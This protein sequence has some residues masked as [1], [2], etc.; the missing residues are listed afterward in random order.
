MKK[1]LIFLFLLVLFSG[2]NQVA[3]THT[4][5]FDENVEIEYSTHVDTTQYVRRVDAFIIDN[6][7]R[8]DYEINVSNFTVSC[9]KLDNKSLG[10]IELLYK[11]NNEIYPLKATIV[12]SIKPLIKVKD[13]TL[14]FKWGKFSKK[15]LL[16]NIIVKDNY[17][18]KEDIKIS[19]VG[20]DSVNKEKSGEYKVTVLA[21]DTSGNQSSKDIKI[22]IEE[23]EE[24]KKEEE[25]VSVNESNNQ[26][27]LENSG[28][29]NLQIQNQ[30]NTQ[31]ESTNI[32][33]QQSSVQNKDYL[34]SDGYDMNSAPSACQADLL[35]SGRSGYCIPIKNEEG[36][37]LGM[38]LTLN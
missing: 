23:K 2:C 3:N 27:T 37:Y 36:I 25:D 14:S 20:L 16:K 13:S 28:Q 9:P 29:N 26:K 34:F 5:I 7:M 22:I 10:Q 12:D 8:G 4:I 35:N 17:D 30:E 19:F 15:S 6:S 32:P 1:N 33:S 21:T 24:K 11:I 18:S 31:Q 38:R